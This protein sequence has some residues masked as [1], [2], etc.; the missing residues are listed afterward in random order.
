MPARPLRAAQA[1]ANAEQQHQQGTGV[2]SRVAAAAAPDAAIFIATV[3]ADY[4]RMVGVSPAPKRGGTR[5]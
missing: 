1:H 3:V 2:V 5:R 4:P